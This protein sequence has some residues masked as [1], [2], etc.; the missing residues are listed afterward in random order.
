MKLFS[1]YPATIWVRVFGTVFSKIS[2][3]MVRSFAGIYLYEKMGQDVVSSASVVIA[4]PAVA[5]I[6]NLVT[7][8]VSDK[9]GRKPVMVGAIFVQG[10]TVLGYLYATD[11]THFLA[12]SLL[13]GMANSLYWPAAQAQIAD[14]I[15]LDKRGEVFALMHAALN[16]GAALGPMIGVTVYKSNPHAAFIASSVGLVLY[17]FLLFFFTEESA[18]IK[19]GGTV[20]TAEIEPA[21]QKS[22][23]WEYLKTRFNFSYIF[24]YVSTHRVI[25]LFMSF[26]VPVGLLYSQVELIVP[27]Q[28]RTRFDHYLET[29]GMLMSINGTCVALLQLPVQ[30]LIQKYNLPRSIGYAYGMMALTALGYGWST[31]VPLFVVAEL[32]FTAGEMIGGPQGQRFISQIA[33]PELRG[34]YFALGSLSWGISGVLGP[35]LGALGMKYFGGTAWFSVLG[36]MILTAA[37]LQYRLTHRALEKISFQK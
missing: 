21:T 32:L 13:A 24:N 11:F 22:S 3:F 37:Y 17:A 34:R 26:S 14:L 29:F 23:R 15:T 2:E 10:L 31:T 12:L 35:I 33:P 20:S 18:P 5:L 1:R 25:F 16:V 7:G 27:L 30:K 36:G 9:L 8:G 6:M 4:G 19:V 28:L